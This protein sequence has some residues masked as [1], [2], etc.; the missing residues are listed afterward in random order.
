MPPNELSLLSLPNSY[1]VH[2]KAHAYA[3]IH[4]NIELMHDHIFP[5]SYVSCTAR[6]FC[7]SCL[8]Q[9]IFQIARASAMPGAPAPCLSN[10]V[11]C[12][13]L[14]LKHALPCI[15]ARTQIQPTLRTILS[16]KPTKCIVWVE[17][18]GNAVRMRLSWN[19]IWSII[20]CVCL[21]QSIR[22]N[23]YVV[24]YIH[25]Y[26]SAPRPS[27]PLY[28]WELFISD[29]AVCIAAERVRDNTIW[30]ATLYPS[31]CVYRQG[32]PWVRRR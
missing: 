9:K 24:I 3:Y 30:N 31:L 7:G 8:L 25:T 21:C 29:A 14:W 17:M 10:A 13:H 26:R 18:K 16:S 6:I 23:M 5:L 22:K 32:S 15:L 1:L 2:F 27:L 12:I 20:Q 28:V 19:E 11:L 4:T